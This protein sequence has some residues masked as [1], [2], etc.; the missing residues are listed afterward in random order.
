[1]RVLIGEDDPLVVETVSMAMSIRWPDCEVL[2]EST[3][4]GTLHTATSEHVDLLILDVNLPDMEGFDVLQEI[5]KVSKVPV[6]MLT[7]RASDRDKVK[8]LEMGADD[9]L[10]KPFSAFELV[11]RASAVLRRSSAEASGEHSDRELIE[12]G[13]VRLNPANAEVTVHDMPV[14]LTPTE[15]RIL[16]LLVRNAGNVV[17][18]ELL[19][20]EVWGIEHSV[21]DN[22]LIKLHMKNLRRKLGD[23]ATRP[24][25]IVTVRGFGYKVAVP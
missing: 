20:K 22:H 15:F 25:I 6:I 21:S 12:A 23:D 5:R 19:L 9:Y 7:V 2:T 8:G 4:G 14:K 24:E 18:P 1:M 16:E 10:A 13:A 3:G 11:A 17:R